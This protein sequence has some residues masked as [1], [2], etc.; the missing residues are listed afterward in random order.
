MKV[1]ILVLLL[2]LFG[3]ISSY[4]ILVIYPLPVKSLSILGHSV[5]KHLVNDG[6]EVTFITTHPIDKH[7]S[8][9]LRQIDVSANIPLLAEASA[10][11]ISNIIG[12]DVEEDIQGVQDLC[13][14][15][16]KQTFQNPNVA[17]LLEGDE[18][19]DLVISDLM[20]SEVYL[21]LSVLYNCPMI[22]IFSMGSHFQAIRL[23]ADPA[24]PAYETNYYG[25]DVPPFTFMQRVK[26]LLGRIKW[27]YYKT[28]H[29]L[30]L[31]K[32]LYEETFN[33]LLAKRG[34]TLPAYEDVLY[35][36]SLMF[37]NEHSAIINRP[38]H[39][40]NFKHIGGIHID[41]PVKPLPKD[42]QDLMDNAPHGVIYFSMGSFWRAKDLPAELVRELLKVFGQLKQK[43]IWKYETNLQDVPKN[44]HIVQWAPQPSILAHPNCKLFI[45]HGG[46]HSSIESIHFGVPII[47]IPVLFDQKLNVNK[48]VAS[49]YAIKLDL[50]YDVPT[51]LIEAI[52][53]MLTD[54][55]YRERVKELSFIYHDKQSKPGAELVFWKCTQN[56]FHPL[57]YFMSR[58]NTKK[59]QPNSD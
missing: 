48:A 57:I 41:D 44:V 58:S 17:K 20:E 7:P 32:Q 28:F 2:S 56:I 51:K 46:H 55:K 11:N 47:G 15:N 19:F 29:T 9:N 1:Y 50:G 49:G 21:G 14:E 12:H 23:I 27:S 34:R 18:H 4:K 42:L 25:T 45:T 36:A 40:Q 35:N 59:K 33:P 24:N 53:T 31:E 3:F 6:H 52:N 39:P 37:A 43:V 30:P 10:W 54:E 16:A 22:W 13:R 26:E 5:V 8:K 38:S